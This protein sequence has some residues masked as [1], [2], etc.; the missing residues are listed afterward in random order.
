MEEKNCRKYD[1]EIVVEKNDR[2]LYKGNEIIQEKVLDFFRKNLFEDEN[3]IYILNTYGN[4]I[5]HGYITVKGFPLFI[6][7]F[8]KDEDKLLLRSNDLACSPIEEWNFFLREDDRIFG[9][10]KNQKYLK[11][12]FSRDFLNFISPH[13]KEKDQKYF[14]ELNLLLLPI[15]EFKDSFEVFP[16]SFHL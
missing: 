4:L 14:L 5:E 6:T 13:L 11:Y 3:G 12:A 2:W 1:S 15:N 10:K 9:M 8:L 16:P 7:N